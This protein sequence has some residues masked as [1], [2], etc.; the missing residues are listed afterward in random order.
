MEII[1]LYFK[2]LDFQNI[3]KFYKMKNMENLKQYYIFKI[4]F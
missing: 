2:N 4:R 3:V 1:E